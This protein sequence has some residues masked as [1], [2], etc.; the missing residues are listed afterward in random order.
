MDMNDGYSSED[1][2]LIVK[3]TALDALDDDSESDTEDGFMIFDGA[4]R[5]FSGGAG[6]SRPDRQPPPSFHRWSE[7]GVRYSTTFW[8]GRQMGSNFLQTCSAPR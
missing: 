3:I 6:T 7:W 1:D 4:R 8:D 2:N 5:C